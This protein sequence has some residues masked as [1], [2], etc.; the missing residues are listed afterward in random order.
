[1]L[2]SAPGIR[3]VTN[4]NRCNIIMES[5][6][7]YL[8]MAAEMALEYLPKLA[9]A[10]L[11]LFVGFKLTNKLSKVLERVLLQM[12]MN[13]SLLTFSRSLADIGL[14]GLLLFTVAAVAGVDITAFV[15]VLAAAGFAIGLALQGSLSNFAAGIIIVLFRPYKV[16]D[17]IEVDGKFGQVEEVEIFNTVIVTPGNKTLIIPNG[18]VVEN[19]VTNYSKKG[20]IRLELSIAIP[21][22]ESFPKLRQIILQELFQI[23]AI[24]KDPEPEVGIESFDSHSLKLAIRPFIRPEDYWQVTFDV[25]ARIK[26]AFHHQNIPVA[27]SDGVELGT[28]GL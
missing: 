25:Y 1:M 13:S 19:V 22:S 4:L 24:L 15:A 3:P 14:K 18:K 27:Y 10:V 12:G 26:S 17:W 23:E 20:H 21:Y 2:F 28:I 7:K 9:L 8:D 16:G 5:L 6:N 11:L